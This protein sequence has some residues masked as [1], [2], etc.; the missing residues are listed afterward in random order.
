MQHDVTLLGSSPAPPAADM[1]S[2]VLQGDGMLPDHAT[3][4]LHGQALSVKPAAPEAL[5]HVNG[6]AVQEETR[7]RC[8]TRGLLLFETCTNRMVGWWCVT[9]LG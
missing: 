2:I 3:L 5:L 1:G 8:G 9:W 4:T 7:L 6:R